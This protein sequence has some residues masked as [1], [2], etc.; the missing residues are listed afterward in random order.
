[1]KVLYIT[2][3][4]KGNGIYLWAKK[5]KSTLTLIVLYLLIII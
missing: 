2:L 4:K 5:Q 1:M 3:I